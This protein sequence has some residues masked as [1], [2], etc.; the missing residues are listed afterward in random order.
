MVRLVLITALALSLAA[1]GCVDASSGTP[2]SEDLA[3]FGVE[4]SVTVIVDEDGFSPNELSIAAN[5]TISV[6]NEGSDPHRARQ[7][8]TPSD[9]R[10]ETGDMLP[11]E[12]IAI[13]LDD[14]GT[15]TLTDPITG[16]SLELD[17]GAPAPVG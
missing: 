9:R 5:S 8:N 2:A 7:T 11:G 12:T 13:H 1:T 10:I 17:V 6:T 14:P 4:P 16:A 15:I 3:D